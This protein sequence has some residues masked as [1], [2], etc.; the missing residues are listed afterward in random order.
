MRPSYERAF[1]GFGEEGADLHR[2]DGQGEPSTM[3][4]EDGDRLEVGA[5]P[6]RIIRDVALGQ[7]GDRVAARGTVLEQA[8]DEGA[9]LGA[10][11]AAVTRVQ[12]ELGKGRPHSG[13]VRASH[14]LPDGDDRLG[15]GRASVGSR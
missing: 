1:E 9:R 8:L 12:Q 4:L 11:M 13:I 2:R 5:L 3:E 6:R 14:G 10:E 15:T 7:R